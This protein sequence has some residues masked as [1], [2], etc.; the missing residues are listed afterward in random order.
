MAVSGARPYLRFASV[1]PSAP[2]TSSRFSG[3]TMFSVILLH[4]CF[5]TFCPACRIGPRRRFGS[6]EVVPVVPSSSRGPVPFA[7]LLRCSVS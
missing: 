1:C 5:E 7:Y 3:D 4:V 6:A 2:R